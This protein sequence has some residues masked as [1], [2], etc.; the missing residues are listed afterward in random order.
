LLSIAHLIILTINFEFI[1]GAIIFDQLSNVSVL[2]LPKRTVTQ[3]T[4][5]ILASSCILQLS[6]T[7][8]HALEIISITSQWCAKA[9]PYAKFLLYFSFKVSI[10]FL[11]KYLSIADSEAYNHKKHT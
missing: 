6:V 11:K 5:T 8:A 4:Q 9:S 1:G 10:S 7:T 2:S 3:G